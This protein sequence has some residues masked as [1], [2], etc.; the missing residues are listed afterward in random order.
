MS[1]PDLRTLDSAVAAR[2]GYTDIPVPQFSRDLVFAFYAAKR[3]QLFEQ[4]YVLARTQRTY[5][6]WDWQVCKVDDMGVLH[7]FVSA[8]SA[9]E[10]ICRAIVV[11]PEAMAVQS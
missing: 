5:M 10:A 1:T 6:A 3:A 2:I 9:A 11:L 8:E 4:G 7:S